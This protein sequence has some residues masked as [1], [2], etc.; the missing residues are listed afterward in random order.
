MHEKNVS[1]IFQDISF[2]S[3]NEYLHVCSFRRVE[4][5]CL[6][7]TF[8]LILLSDHTLFENVVSYALITKKYIIILY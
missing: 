1:N 2:I 7:V 5:A 8:S 4:Y 3:L 6:I